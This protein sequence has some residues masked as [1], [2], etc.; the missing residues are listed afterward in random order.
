MHNLG[1]WNIAQRSAER[2]AL[3]GPDG[4]RIT[5]GE[6]LGRANQL[7]HGLRTQG[8]EAGDTIATVF[9]NEVAVVELYL[10]IAQAGIYLVPINHHLLAPEIAYIVKDSQAKGFVCSEQFANQCTSAMNFLDFN[11]QARFSTGVVPG[12]R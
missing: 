3:V 4:E 1:F 9:K 6:L 8:F 12:F 10:A 11:P 7:V 2:L 5:A